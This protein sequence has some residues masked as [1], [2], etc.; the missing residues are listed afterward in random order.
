VEIYIV[1]VYR[2]D[3]A[4]AALTGRVEYAGT[5]DSLRFGSSDE[6][7]EFMLRVPEAR[8]ATEPTRGAGRWTASKPRQGRRWR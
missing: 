1:Q 5:G 2:R 7:W 8:A 6:L 4:A 3:V